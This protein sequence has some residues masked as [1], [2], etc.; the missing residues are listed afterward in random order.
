MSLGVSYPNIE[1]AERGLIENLISQAENNS[2]IKA[3]N[4]KQTPPQKTKLGG[5]IYLHGMGNLTDWTQGCVALTNSD[6]KELF[7]NI[8]IGTPVK[9]VP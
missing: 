6:I 9:I 5:E 4:E 7:D 3:I 8:P 1:D 2:I